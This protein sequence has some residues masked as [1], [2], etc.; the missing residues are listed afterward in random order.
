ME[1]L[2]KSNYR[3]YKEGINNM[4]EFLGTVQVSKETGIPAY[5]IRAYCREGRVRFL[6]SGR[7]YLFNLAWLEHDLYKIANENMRSRSEQKDNFGQRKDESKKEVS[8]WSLFR[9]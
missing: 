5:R 7:R 8:R 9:K 2:E 3:N 4:S 6:T 1:N